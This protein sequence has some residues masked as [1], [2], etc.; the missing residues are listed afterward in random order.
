MSIGVAM[1]ARN[2]ELVI[3]RALRSTASWAKA[4]VVHDTGSEDATAQQ[5][6]ETAEHHGVPLVLNW[7]EWADFATNRNLA[8]DAARKQ[9]PEVDYWLS[10]DADE[11]ATLV[12]G[13]DDSKLDGDLVFVNM[14]SGNSRYWAPRLIR[15]K[16]PCRW[17]GRCHEV[18][19]GGQTSERWQG[20]ELYHVGDGHD[21]PDARRLSRNEMLLRTDLREHPDDPRV[22]FYLA[23][24]LHSQGRWK[25][26]VDYYKRRASV[27]LIEGEE[28]WYAHYQMGVCQLAAGDFAGVDTM[29]R[30]VNRRPW[31]AEPLAELATY[32]LR[33]G[34]EELGKFFAFAADSLPYPETDMLFIEDALYRKE[35]R[36]EVVPSDP[37]YNSGR[38]RRRPGRRPGWRPRRRR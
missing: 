32:Y 30:A 37:E 20:I 22:I 36:E 28:G 17:Q 9:F 4:W 3:D 26:A 6:K 10:L 38:P 14:T 23:Q 7:D 2:E 24:T 33:E 13:A 35:L 18:P 1:I 21:S 27:G 15:A 25:E 11:T 34:C 12:E 16:G 5:V 29:L 8:L 19:E 31:R